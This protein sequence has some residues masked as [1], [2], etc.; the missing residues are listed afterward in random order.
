MPELPEVETIRRGLESRLVAARVEEVEV[1]EGRLRRPIDVGALRRLRGGRIVAFRRRAKYLVVCLDRDR[2][3]LVHFG[4]SGRLRLARPGEPGERHVHVVWLLEVPGED[5]PVELRL[6]DPR[7]FGIV[8]VLR[9]SELDTHPLLATIGPEPLDAR[10]DAADLAERARRSRRTIKSFLMDSRTIAGIG[11]IYASEAL[12]H[13]RIHPRARAGR[14]SLD[15]WRRLLEAVRH[16][17]EAAIAAGG[18]TLRDFRDEEGNL[19][20]FATELAVYGREGE[21][22][23]ECHRAL[24]RIVLDGRSTFYCARCQRV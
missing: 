4:M 9:E 5:E 21:P 20:Y 13:A 3:I 2:A 15:R 22:C 17:L 8:E 7:R 10:T 18:T 6:R 12:W 19:G 16:V 24:R 14:L 1:L 23:A 11:N